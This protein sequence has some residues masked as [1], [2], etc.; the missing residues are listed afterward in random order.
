MDP[1]A[2][3]N[4]PRRSFLGGLAGIAALGAADLLT[5]DAGAQVTRK[6]D[7]GPGPAGAAPADPFAGKK[8]VLAIGDVHTG[9]QHDSVSHALATIERLGR[10]SGL[11]VTYIRTDTQLITKD[12]IYG[13]GKYAA[14]PN[15]TRGVNAKNL[16]Y[17]DA[18]FFYGLGEEDL[19]DKQKTDL[20]SFVHDDGKGFVGAHS[21]IDAFY[22]WPEYGQMVGAYFDNH[23]WGV[24]NAPIIVEEPSFP[25]MKKFPHEFT[26]RDEIY[27]PTNSPYSREN[28][29]VLA[30]MDASKVDVKVKDLH[31][32]DGDFPVAW[33]KKYGKGNVFYS[34]LGHP[35]EAWDNPAIQTMYLEAIKWSLGLTTYVPR[36][37]PLPGRL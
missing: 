29:D 7:A 15:G 1:Y 34:S 2:K 3:N 14:P 21:A 11:F 37:H 32:T 20:L 13:T 35:D 25:G 36:P 28:V 22:N 24:L 27:V 5:P 33:V 19:S 16:D 18:I 30:R 26:V 9:Y 6:P 8:R 4:I 23:P 10:E 12:K 31:R 17:F